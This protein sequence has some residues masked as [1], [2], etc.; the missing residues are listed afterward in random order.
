MPQLLVEQRRFARKAFLPV[1]LVDGVPFTTAHPRGSRRPEM[2]LR[3]VGQPAFGIGQ[4]GVANVEP[5]LLHYLRLHTRVQMPHHLEGFWIVD[6]APHHLA[7]VPLVVAGT[8]ERTG[9]GQKVQMPVALVALCRWRMQRQCKREITVAKLLL[10]E[11]LADLK[12]SFDT[13]VHFQ[14]LVWDVGDGV[15]Q[16]LGASLRLAIE[17][18][19]GFESGDCLLDRIADVGLEQDTAIGR[20]MRTPPNIK[21]RA[22]TYPCLGPMAVVAYAEE[23]AG[24]S[25]AVDNLA[26]VARQ[27][28]CGGEPTAPRWPVSLRLAFD[29]GPRSVS[30]LDP[31]ALPQ[32]PTTPVRFAQFLLQSPLRVAVFPSFLFLGLPSPSDD[33]RERAG[34]FAHDPVS[35]GSADRGPYL[36]GIANLKFHC[37]NP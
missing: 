8:N 37:A 32:R 36:T 34:P 31:D 33:L 3:R 30:W 21:R 27:L 18:L 25:C 5:C 12:H 15:E 35:L 26:G 1:A 14:Q 29:H 7:D 2:L 20:F 23:D 24:A 6:L 19:D 4:G 22:P 11:A 10:R 28:R 17:H 16:H 9:R 13:A